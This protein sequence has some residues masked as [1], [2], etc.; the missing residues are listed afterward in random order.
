[1]DAIAIVSVNKDK[2]SETFIRSQ[3]AMLPFKVHFFYGAYLPLFYGEGKPFLSLFRKENRFTR[4]VLRFVASV[5]P[6]IIQK[7]VQNYCIKHQIK[8]VL[9]HYGPVG[10]QMLPVSTKA[11][12]P[13]FVYFHGYDVNRGHEKA[14]YGKHYPELVRRAAAVFGVSLEMVDKLKAMG[15]MSEKIVYNP[16]GADTDLFKPV[17]AA[18]NPPVIVSVG[19]FDDT[20]NHAALIR[21]FALV[22]KE[23]PDARLVLIG[24]GKNLKSCRRL[25]TKLN[26]NHLISFK[27]ALPHP[28]VAAELAKARV[29]ALHSVTTADGDREGA[30]VSIMEAGACGLPVVA[31]NHAGINDIVIHSQTGFLVEENDVK[32]MANALLPFLMQAQLAETFGKAAISHIHRH[33]SLKHNVHRI[34]TL[35]IKA[36]S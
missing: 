18:A 33:F 12:I 35:I 1:M 11:N 21:A 31:T 28:D 13:L 23:C 30:P 25:A 2:Y 3:A 17:D 6:S 7:A 14:A 22:V 20:K 24:E 29:F 26:L 27:G 5:F 8:A 36:I 4:F 32:A 9:A 19:R 16:C 10:L 34:S 15:C